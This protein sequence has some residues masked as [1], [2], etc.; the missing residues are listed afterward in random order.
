ML[1]QATGE[2]EKLRGNIQ[3]FKKLTVGIKDHLLQ[4][5]SS[6]QCL[7]VGSNERARSMANE[8]Q[9]A[10]LDV[11]PILSPT[12]AKGSERLRICLHSFNSDN[13]LTLLSKILHQ[14]TL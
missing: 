8:L 2:I 7:V 1:P 5:D 3:L 9:S 10:G 14:H 12:V 4:S 6:I 13:E 11:R